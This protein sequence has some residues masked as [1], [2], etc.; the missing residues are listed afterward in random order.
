MMEARIQK[1]IASRNDFDGHVSLLELPF[2]RSV[3][4][5]ECGGT[6]YK[7]QLGVFEVL[8]L[9]DRIRRMIARRERVEKIREIALAEGFETLIDDA[10][11]KVVQG[12]TDFKEIGGVFNSK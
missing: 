12:V 4:C 9:S 8:K 11:H 1:I 7:G 10:F 3:G 6:G 2:Y 5:D